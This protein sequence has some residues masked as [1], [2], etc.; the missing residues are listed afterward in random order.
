[1]R[2]ETSI[3]TE[4]R[5]I[6]RPLPPRN[7]PHQRPKTGRSILPHQT[8]VQR[9]RI[10][11]TPTK[12]TTKLPLIYG[13]QGVRTFPFFAISS[14]F[15]S[16]SPASAPQSC[17]KIN[18]HTEK[19]ELLVSHRKQRIGAQI[20]RHTSRGPRFSFSLSH[21]LFSRI[22]RHTLLLGFAVSHRKQS[23]SQILIATRTAFSAHPQKS[24]F[25]MRQWP[26]RRTAFSSTSFTSFASSTSSTSSTSFVSLAS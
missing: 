4:A 9:S 19:I 12:Q 1:M 26:P 24:L 3:R 14:L 7:P 5:F 8:T 25:A 15:C 18:R 17:A 13:K 2:D 21:V 20:N 16:L 23:P 22:N 6:C 10:S 11:L